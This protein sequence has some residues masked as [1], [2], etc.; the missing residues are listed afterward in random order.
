MAMTVVALYK[1]PSLK[2]VFVI[3]ASQKAS[4]DSS[5]P[6]K[7]SK[8]RREYFVRVLLSKGQGDNTDIPK[9]SSKILPEADFLAVLEQYRPTARILTNQETTCP[10]SLEYLTITIT[11]N[12]SNILVCQHFPE[13]VL[14]FVSPEDIIEVS[15]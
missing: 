4:S 9:W 2:Q 14:N 10:P 8:K 5:K 13:K 1:I 6:S 7:A 11:R 12:L 15:I 3:V